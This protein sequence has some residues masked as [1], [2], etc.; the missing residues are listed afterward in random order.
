M[1]L[2]TIPALNGKLPTTV[3]YRINQG[4]G[5]NSALEVFNP[6]AQF[7][8]GGSVSEFGFTVLLTVPNIWRLRESPRLCQ[9]RH[10][11]RLILRCI[12]FSASH[13]SNADNIAPNPSIE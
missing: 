10:A 1:S 5:L 2:R 3:A 13:Q 12:R 7:S 9:T 11:G 4:S 8:P 6:T